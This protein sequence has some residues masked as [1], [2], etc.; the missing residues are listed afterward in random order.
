MSSLLEKDQAHQI[1]DR[2]P[3]NATWEDLIHEIYV[4]SAVER[5][6]EDSRAERVMEVRELRKQY[7]LPE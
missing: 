2:L 5:G 4:R 6:L 7:G 1:I 3:A